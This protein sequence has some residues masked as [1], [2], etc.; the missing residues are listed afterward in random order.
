MQR[1]ALEDI[2]AGM[3]IE[4]VPDSNNSIEDTS[5]LSMIP[6]LGK[7]INKNF[8]V[9][10]GGIITNDKS[11]D[12]IT[13][14]FIYTIHSGFDTSY[15]KADINLGL[16]VKGNNILKIK[17]EYY[18]TSKIGIGFNIKLINGD[19]DYYDNLY[20]ITGKGKMLVDEVEEISIGVEGQLLFGNYK[21]STVTKE[22]KQYGWILEPSLTSPFNNELSNLEVTGGFKLGSIKK[23]NSTTNVSRD[24]F[25]FFGS[26][27]IDEIKLE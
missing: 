4:M 17:T 1:N 8:E 24:Y 3:R 22:E 12:M 19:N 9:A 6:Y 15:G 16:D 26:I 2:Y 5:Y 27:D 25:G 18:I 14:D 13:K 7:N 23:E 20:A 10:L 11:T 21:N